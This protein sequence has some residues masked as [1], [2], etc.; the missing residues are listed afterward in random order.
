MIT[1]PQ[2]ERFVHSARTTSK[3]LDVSE[4]LLRRWRKTGEGPDYVRLGVRRIGYHPDDIERWLA[5]RRVAHV[6]RPRKSAEP[7]THP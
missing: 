6:P 7:H 2:P 3:L 1:S 4:D 5:A